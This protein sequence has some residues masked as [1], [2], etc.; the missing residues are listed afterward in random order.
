MSTLFYRC[1]LFF[2]TS[3]F[4]SFWHFCSIHSCLVWLLL[5]PF[6]FP[7]FWSLLFSLPV[8]DDAFFFNFSFLILFPTPY[9]KGKWKFFFSL[10][11]F[12][13][14]PAFYLFTCSY[15][16][17][18]H[19]FLLGN[20][21]FKVLPYCSRLKNSNDIYYFWYYLHVLFLL[22]FFPLSSYLMLIINKPC[23][24]YKYKSDYQGD[25]ISS[26]YLTFLVNQFF[27]WGGFISSRSYL[28][29]HC[30]YFLFLFHYKQYFLFCIFFLSLQFF[31]F[32]VSHFI[33]K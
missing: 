12:F 24:F 29:F 27:F 19:T 16:F 13:F 22:S 2:S 3:F 32:F 18:I 1:F 11:S 4:T 31:F 33:H 30:L 20:F 17:I 26:F 6:A 23:I 10:L 7:T 9:F 8:F 5:P 28:L 25:H 14:S 21:I 15:I